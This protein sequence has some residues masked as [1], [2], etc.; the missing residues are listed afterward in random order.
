MNSPTGTRT[1]VALALHLAWL[2]PALSISSLWAGC[3]GGGQTDD[4]GRIVDFDAPPRCAERGSVADGFPCRCASDCLE[5][6]MCVTEDVSQFAGG[7]CRR[8]CLDAT[9]PEGARCEGTTCYATC[10]ATAD[11]GPRRVCAGGIC[12]PWCV[13]DA[14]CDSGNCNEHSG[15]CLPSGVA[16]AG[17]E[18]LWSPCLR[19]E[20]CLSNFC[21]TAPQVCLTS[22]IVSLQTC[23]Q[24]ALCRSGSSTG[25]EHDWG[26]CT[27]TCS[28][29][30]DCPATS[31]GC[32]EG[33]CLVPEP[34]CFGATGAVADGDACT[35]DRQCRSGEC[36]AEVDHGV[37]GGFCHRPCGG[38]AE[39]AE[40]TLCRNDSCATACTSSAD[41]RAGWL[42]DEGACS[43]FQC[44]ED[45]DCLTYDHCDP[46]LGRCGAESHG[47]GPGALCSSGE[48]CRSG[49]C[50]TAWSG[51]FCVVLCSFAA[52]DCP[53]G[54]YCRRYSRSVDV[55]LCAPRCTTDADCLQTDAQCTSSSGS[56]TYCY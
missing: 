1:L 51:G 37:A 17:T 41:C 16:P 3:G 48:D 49:S 53:D 19:D 34:S 42:C 27:P 35:C 29:D 23:P 18:A 22:C 21:G 36:L 28:R 54:A 56:P 44:S 20:D 45:S 11:C 5:G 8:S 2:G 26:M 15:T 40:G 12:R 52:Q 46:Y 38:D 25:P 10:S 47:G 39:C 9:C 43:T 50:N 24:G 6:T 30:E 14:D 55:G 32:L 4:A 7:F 31:V 33:H 13:S